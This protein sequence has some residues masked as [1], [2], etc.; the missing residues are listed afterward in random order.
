GPRQPLEFWELELDSPRD[1][2]I[3]VRVAAAGIC[4]TD[5]V[6]RDAGL[7]A[8]PAVLGH[9]GAGVVEATGKAVR[10]V[11]PGDRVAITFRSCGSCPR[12]SAGH[13]AYCFHMPQLNY[14]GAR[15]D[16]SRALRRDR[17]PVGSNFFGQSAFATHV[18]AY[19][20]N[21]VRLPVDLPWAI[22]A[23]LGCGVQTGA[24]AVLR[25]LACAQGASILIAGA[26][27]VG[28]SAVMAATIR[29]CSPIVVIE[30]LESR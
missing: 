13:P 24:G 9:E 19:E 23:T 22:A 8:H 2:E 15:P 30:P 5:L 4:H 20:R 29:Q 17:E 1:D 27:P 3:L 18:L 7:I 16:G 6:Y 14:A 11:S 28:L 10:K 25:A 12:C 26:G 21:T